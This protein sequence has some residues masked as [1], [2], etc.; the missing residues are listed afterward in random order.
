MASGSTRAH[1]STTAF[2]CSSVS[3]PMGDDAGA[4]TAILSLRPPFGFLQPLSPEVKGGMND[5]MSVP[6]RS[7]I[8]R[9]SRIS[10]FSFLNTSYSNQIYKPFPKTM[11]ST[12][13]RQLAC[14]IPP[15]AAWASSRNLVKYFLRD[16]VV[17]RGHCF[18]APLNEA[19]A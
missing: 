1:E 8:F 3:R 11:Q 12:S 15:L 16:S 10:F 17:C 19:V 2:L 13:K 4:C 14:V 7:S 5:A 18:L 6:A 9:V